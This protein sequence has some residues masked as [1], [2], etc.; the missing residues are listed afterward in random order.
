M[1]L[2]ASKGI[3]MRLTEKSKFGFE[4]Q[5]RTTDY[6]KLKEWAF[7]ENKP[8]QKALQLFVKYA[9]NNL[10]RQSINTSIGSYGLK[11]RV[12]E[13]S[14]A[15]QKIDTS[16]SYEYI[17]NEDFIIA[18]VQAGFDLKNTEPSSYRP[19]PNYYFNLKVLNGDWVNDMVNY[20]KME[21]N[22]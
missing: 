11:H 5:V 10:K 6:N 7:V 21:N 19:G 14:R 8:T 3:E 9:T 1:G 20:Y 16:Y 12:E 2:S 18:M 22:L 13:L 17:G 4:G 15:L